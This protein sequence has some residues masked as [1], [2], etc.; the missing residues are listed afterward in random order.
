MRILWRVGIFSLG[1]L[2]AFACGGDPS[3]VQKP[4][5]DDD[6]EGGE[7]AVSGTTGTGGTAG[8]IPQGGTGGDTT[9]GKGGTAG[10]GAEGGEPG[11]PCDG[12]VCDRGMHCVD[13]DCED[14]EDCDDDLD[15]TEVKYCN[16]GTCTDDDCTPDTKSCDGNAVVTCNSNGSANPGVECESGGYFTSMCVDTGSGNAGCGCEDDWD[17]PPFTV[18]DVNVCTGTGVAP[19]CTLP[20][21][22]FT[23][24]LPQLEFR[25]GGA[26]HEYDN[27]G[28]DDNFD[29]TDVPGDDAD[30]DA[31]GK[32]FP[33]SAQVVSP[34]IVINLDDDNGDGKANELDFPEIVFLSHHE[35]QRDTNGVIRAVHG[36]G[37]N[38]GQDFFALCGNPARPMTQQASYTDASGAY[39]S[40]GAAVMVDCATDG[41]AE[42]RGDALARS[43]SAPAAGDIDGDG[44]PEIVVA[45]ENK[46]F[47]ILNNRGE[48]LFTSPADVLEPA[49]IFYVSPA[50]ALVNLDFQGLAEIVVGNRVITLTSSGSTFAID[51][52]FVGAEARGT[53]DQSGFINGPTACVADLTSDPGLE[54]V[55]GPTAYKLPPSPPMSCGTA[56]MPCPLDVVWNA[57]SALAAEQAEGLCAVADVMGACTSVADCATNPP[58]PAEPLDGAPEVV[59]IANGHLV[60]LAGDTGTVL[61]DQQVPSGGQRGGAPN[62][63]D[64]DG[65]G[66]PEI[67]TALENFYT[68]LDLQAPSTACPAWPDLLDARTAP[69]Q[70]NPPRDAGGMSCRR[71]S[72]CTTA[73]TTCNETSG[74]CVCLHNGWKRDTEDDSSRVTSSSIF[75]F[76][77]DGAAEVVY[78]DECYFRVYDGSTGSVYLALPSV[79]RT[80]IENPVVADVDNDGNAEIVFVQNNWVEQCDEGGDWDTGGA[81]DSW[82]SGMND[83]RKDSLPNGIEVWGDPTDTWVAARRVWNQHAYHVTNVLE[84]GGIPLHEPESW[85]PLNGRLYNTYR[86]QPRNYGVAPD[87]ALPAIQIS[88]PDAACGELSDTI[89]ITVLVKNQGDLRVGPGVVLEFFGT[90]DGDEEALL[91]GGGAPITVTLTKSLEPGASTLVTVEYEVGWNAAPNDDAL[92]DSVRV[93]I[94]GADRERE[95]VEDNNEVEIGVGSTGEMLADLAVS[96]DAAACNGSVTVTVENTGSESASDILVEIYAG[97]PSSGG[98]LLGEITIDGPLDPGDSE[99]VTADVFA[100]SYS[101]DVTIWVVADP[102]DTIAECNDANNVAEGPMLDC[103][104]E[105]H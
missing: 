100:G 14:N 104:N 20:P 32:A 75:D 12:V 38:K 43:S 73:G 91:D 5:G 69:P 17:C 18:C 6:G 103:Q 105:P 4:S 21:T 33:W 68:V 37:P 81:L 34:P 35:T 64:F 11:D 85:R 13:G 16:N 83:V 19:T 80:I 95:C 99:T 98:T 60:I 52:I 102:N 53:Q 63:D 61:Y 84:G 90:W 87:L 1:P 30:D 42:S 59:L 36:G 72:D 46:G 56:A 3:V 94:D 70:T 82:P 48:P 7:G 96:V 8:T 15:C 51:R 25:W 29:G 93:V 47:M 49:G 74:E 27:N 58:G 65:D 57:R 92:P 101:S 24:V 39:W 62:I 88:S 97:D 26:N 55:A 67:A 89:Q 54:I 41:N 77:G 28:G 76:N 50:P 71:D 66:F 22:P 9:G 2:L 10:N 40:E 23:D 78:N 31:T 44:F 86:S 79:S 45:L